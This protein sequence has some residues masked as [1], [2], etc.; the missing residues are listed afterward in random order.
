[1]DETDSSL[2]V[3]RLEIM[4]AALIASLSILTAATA[5]YLS[6]SKYLTQKVSERSGN[7]VTRFPESK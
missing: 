2:G 6:V 7:Y 4:I 1:M 5:Y 3:D